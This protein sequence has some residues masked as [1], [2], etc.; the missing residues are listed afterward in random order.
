MNVT[1]DMSSTDLL[2]SMQALR[3]VEIPC[4][5]YVRPLEYASWVLQPP[6]ELSVYDV[7]CSLFRFNSV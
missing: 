3:A 7:P 5:V 4:L 2:I 1:I 6:F